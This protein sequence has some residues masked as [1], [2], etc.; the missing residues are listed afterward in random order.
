[1]SI[2]TGIQACESQCMPTE[3]KP[4]TRCNKEGVQYSRTPEVERQIESALRQ[5]WEG[6]VHRAAVSDRTSPMYLQEET[7]VYLI[8]EALRQGDYA[9]FTTIFSALSKRC[10]SYIEVH[11]YSFSKDR[12]EDAFQNV[13]RHVIERIMGLD[14]D[15][16]DFFQVRFWLALKRAMFTEH[17]KQTKESERNEKFVSMDEEIKGEDVEGEDGAGPCLDIPDP[18]ISQEELALLSAGMSCLT[19]KVKEVFILRYYQGWP[20]RS[21][22]G[23]EPTLSSYFRVTPRTIQNWLQRAEEALAKWREGK[24]K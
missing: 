7:L 10:V 23:N 24:R 11:F 22:D 18:S 6:R 5:D 19:G 4:L 17:K 8:R 13:M 1:M 20:I 3:V 2:T 16:G 9:A 21:E 12:Q 14:D 15:R